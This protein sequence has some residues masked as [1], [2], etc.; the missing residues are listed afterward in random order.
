MYEMVTAAFGTLRT[1]EHLLVSDGRI[2]ASRLVFDT[3]EVRKAQVA[4]A[5]SA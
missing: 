3:Y 1:A 4:Q 2:H 5:P